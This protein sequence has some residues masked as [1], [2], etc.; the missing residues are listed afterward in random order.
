MPCRPTCR[1]RL[2]AMQG[3][4]VVCALAILGAGCAPAGMPPPGALPAK[5]TAR[6]FSAEGVLQDGWEH[7][8]LKGQT[9]YTI[10]VL[11]GRPAIR[12]VGARSASLLVRRVSVDPRRCPTAQW[13]WRATRIQESAQLDV[14]RRED[15]AAS[16]FLLF[17]DPGFL[18]DPK[19]VP[20]VRYVWTN[21]RAPVGAVVDSPYLPGTVRS[22]VLRS[23]AADQ[24]G[25][26]TESRNLADD[27]KLAFPEASEMPE[28]IHAVA[29]FTDNDQ[30]G[31]PAEA[32]YGEGRVGCMAAAPVNRPDTQ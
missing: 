29:L 25:W 24:P 4:A 19:P 21:G 16:V 14:R 1:C 7:L 22:I 11:D 3:R 12:A 6:L 13:S 20:T 23:G 30:T 5:H 28:R 8:P 32:Y 17:G 10:A 9:V 27:F 2:A 18:Y 15:V 26:V 31:E